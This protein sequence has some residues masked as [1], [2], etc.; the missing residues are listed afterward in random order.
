MCGTQHMWMNSSQRTRHPLQWGPTGTH[1]QTHTC[2]I[3]RA[4]IVWMEAW[5][6]LSGA[7]LYK[8]CTFGNYRISTNCTVFSTVT[9]TKTSSQWRRRRRQSIHK[10]TRSLETSN[11]RNTVNHI[12][13][14]AQPTSV[15]RM[16]CRHESELGTMCSPVHI[17]KKTIG[18][19]TK[20]YENGNK[21]LCLWIS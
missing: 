7:L 9:T 10:Y 20:Q 11:I 21:I 13:K 17:K 16:C 1:T 2:S 14:I 5:G 19:E 12:W 4:I 3:T 15:S 18:N 6:M 8:Y